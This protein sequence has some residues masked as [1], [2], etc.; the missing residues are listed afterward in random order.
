MTCR[1][2]IEK[3]IGR[4][5]EQAAVDNLFIPSFPYLSDTYF[6]LESISKIVGH[7]LQQEGHGREGEGEE[8]ADEDALAFY[9]HSSG[10]GGLP[11]PQSA[12]MKVARV[13]DSFLAEV[14]PDANLSV[15]KFVTFAELM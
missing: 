14:A 1:A 12:I 2:E 15:S 8:T 13:L 3:R 4:Q 6:D 11:P 7:F 9:E 10:G 5:L